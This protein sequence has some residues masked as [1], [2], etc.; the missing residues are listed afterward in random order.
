MAA[1]VA[2]MLQQGLHPREWARYRATVVESVAELTSPT[3]RRRRAPRRARPAGRSPPRGPPGPGAVTGMAPPTRIPP[4]TRP[5]ASTEQR[6]RL[7]VTA[8]PHQAAR[9]GSTWSAIRCSASCGATSRDS[10][11]RG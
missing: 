11:G 10:R 8:R 5:A 3:S 9:A 4:P 7:L 1:L 2:T 6:L